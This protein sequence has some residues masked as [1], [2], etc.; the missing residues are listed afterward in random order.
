VTEVV[1]KVVAKEEEAK[2]VAMV[3]VGWEAVAP[4]EVEGQ[5]GA[6]EAGEMV[7]RGG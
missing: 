7:E 5:A 3:V 2:E 6:M 4:A 1:A